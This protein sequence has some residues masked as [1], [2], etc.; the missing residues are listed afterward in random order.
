MRKGQ[1]ISVQNGKKTVTCDLIDIEYTPDRIWVRLP[2]NNVLSMNKN[3]K[4]GLYE[5]SIAG[6]DLQVDPKDN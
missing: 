3:L 5:G 6:I 2:T 1:K 4:N